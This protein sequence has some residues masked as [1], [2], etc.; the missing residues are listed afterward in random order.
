MPALRIMG[1]FYDLLDG[2]AG[3]GFCDAFLAAGFTA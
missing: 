1:D 2:F 3:S